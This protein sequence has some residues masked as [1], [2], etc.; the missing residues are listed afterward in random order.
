MQKDLLDSE[1]LFLRLPATERR[2]KNPPPRPPFETERLLSLF[3]PLKRAG[4]HCEEEEG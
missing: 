4:T 2:Q 3:S 1:R